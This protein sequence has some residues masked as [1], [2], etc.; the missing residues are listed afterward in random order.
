MANVVMLLVFVVLFYLILWRPQSKRA[1]EH[2]ELVSSLNKGDEVVT[3]GGILGRI[4]N[5]T[6][7][8]VVLQVSDNVELPVQ[9][10][11]IAASLPKGTLK[12]VQVA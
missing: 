5:V 12:S 6:D 11:A 8:F 1:K 2:R 10:V 4:V 9:K 7:E 3:N